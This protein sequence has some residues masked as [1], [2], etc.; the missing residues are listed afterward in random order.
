MTATRSIA[1][2]SCRCCLEEDPR[3]RHGC[4]DHTG[5]RGAVEAAEEV[6]RGRRAAL[7]DFRLIDPPGGDR[8]GPV[9]PSL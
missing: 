5:P 7:K 2:S 4:Q 9:L 8:A 6:T 3:G 1:A